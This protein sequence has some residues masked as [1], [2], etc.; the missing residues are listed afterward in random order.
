MSGNASDPF[1]MILKQ[2]RQRK[3][4]TQQ[5][6]ASALGVH[7]NT[8]GR[9]EE[10]SFLPESK[11]LVLDLARCLYLDEQ[12]A[13][14]LLDASLLAPAPLWSV[15]YLRNPFFTGREKILAEMRTR[16]ALG[17]QMAFGQSYALQGLG[18]VGKTQIALEY[19]YRSALEYNAVFWIGAETFEQTHT[20]LLRI[21]ERLNL[22]ESREADQRHMVTAVQRWLET[23]SEWL[24]IWDNLEDLDLLQE[25][26]PSFRQG[27]VLM[28]TRSQALGTIARGIN[29]A[30]MEEEEAVLFLLRRT[31]ILEADATDEQFHQMAAHRTAEYATALELVTALGRLPLALDQAGAYIDEAR[32]ELADFLSLFRRH[33]L[34]LLQER[35]VHTGHPASVVKTVMLLFEKLQQSHRVAADFLTLCCF[36]APEDI[37]EALFTCSA[38]HLPPNLQEA[39]AEPLVFHALLKSLFAYSLMQRHPAHQTLTVHRLVQEVLKAQMS[40]VQQQE[41]LTLLIHLLVQ[42]FPQDDKAVETWEWCEQLLPHTLHCL[43]QIAADTSTRPEELCQLLTRAAAYLY[44]RAQYARAEELYQRA[45]TWQAWIPQHQGLRPVLVRAFSG[46]ADLKQR[47]GLYPEAEEYYQSGLAALDQEQTEDRSQ[48]IDLLRGL[49]NLYFRQGRYQEAEPLYLQVLALREKT[50]GPDHAQVAASLSNLAMLYTTQC[51]YQEAEPLLQRAVRIKERIHG[52]NHLKLATPLNNLAILYFYRGRYQEAEETFWQ[53]I[54][55]RETAQTPEHP[56]LASPLANLAELYTRQGRQQEAEDFFQRACSIL[57]QSFGPNHPELAYILSGWADLCTDRGEYQRAE[58]LLR[59]AADIWG[60]TNTDNPD[61]AALLYSQA[62]LAFH[63]GSYVK[64]EEYCQQA[65]TIW[66]QQFGPNHANVAR[67]FHLSGRL[68]LAQNQDEKAE[69]VLKQALALRQALLGEEHPDVADTRF[70]LATISTRR[71]ACR[72]YPHEQKR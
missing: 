61:R 46:L 33:P 63:Q 67:V 30:P 12:E 24:L 14:Q 54:L 37:P 22:P 8:I 15:P 39:L 3:R 42:A 60:Q 9:W 41:W 56:D 38:T 52:K 35:G 57:E 10:G 65:L 2:L 1:G 55:I 16:L 27:T 53:A 62:N 11:A 66:Q 34:Q 18:G 43:K 64:A 28:T 17:Q 45:L 50:L 58:E 49:S 47:Q 40:R 25:F 13:R 70:Y 72:T 6:L 29:L 48:R 44:Q 19:A 32:C 51:R 69:Q 36:L 68:W 21:A 26:L 59:R 5:Q 20:S 31:H 4:L 7:R 71:N 23:H